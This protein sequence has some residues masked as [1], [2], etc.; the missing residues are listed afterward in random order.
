MCS[1]LSPTRPMQFWRTWAR[2]F[3]RPDKLLSRTLRTGEENRNGRSSAM[4]SLD[5]AVENCQE[6]R[7]KAVGSSYV[8]LLA[9]D[10][11]NAGTA[12]G[13]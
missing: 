5:D 7:Q 3:L 6:G 4:L 8:D 11:G 12:Q 1:V 10:L 9:F 2:A 13:T